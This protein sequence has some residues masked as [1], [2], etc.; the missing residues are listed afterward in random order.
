MCITIPLALSTAADMTLIVPVAAKLQNLR[1]ELVCANCY[2]WNFVTLHKVVKET[3]KACCIVLPICREADEPALL[4]YAI[5][6]QVKHD[7]IN[8]DLTSHL[9]MGSKP[10]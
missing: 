10:I 8:S 2:K 6:M 7:S 5:L 4:S 9:Q 1:I 3:A